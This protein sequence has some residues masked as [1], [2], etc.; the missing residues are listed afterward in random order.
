MLLKYNDICGKTVLNDCLEAWR[1]IN[2]PFEYLARNFNIKTSQHEKTAV[3][4]KV[5]HIKHETVYQFSMYK[6][7]IPNNFTYLHEFLFTL[8]SLRNI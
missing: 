2:K 3:Y 8:T 4:G 7:Q 1:R 5:R 6:H